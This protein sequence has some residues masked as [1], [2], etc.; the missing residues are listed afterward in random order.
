MLEDYWVTRQGLE[1]PEQRRPK[2]APTSCKV[3]GRS[4]S[5][6]QDE[7]IHVENQP[8]RKGGVLE[9]IEGIL[10]G[11]TLRAWQSTFNV[12]ALLITSTR[13]PLDT[14]DTAEVSRGKY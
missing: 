14:S 2:S 13:D 1:L 3:K 5:T 9:C 12:P 7:H 11:T 10:R 4:T 6:P 8:G